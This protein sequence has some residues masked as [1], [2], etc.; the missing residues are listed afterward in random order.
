MAQTIIVTGG[1]RGIGKAILMHFASKGF[2][3]GFCSLQ[4]AHVESLQK[5]LEVLFPQQTIFGRAVDMRKRE[6]V[7]AFGKEVINK[8][9]EI[10]ILVNN[11]GTFLPGMVLEEPEGQLE[12]LI[13]T[14]LYS[15]YYMSRAIAPILIRSGKGHIFNI[16][17][18]AG[19]KAY[20]NGGSYSISKFAM[21]GLSKALREELKD[22]KV[23]VT[24]V[25]PGAVLTDSWSGVD[26][27]EDRFIAAA[28]V[29]KN[30]FDVHAL[31]DRTVI[32]DIVL[33]PQ[34]GDI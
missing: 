29:A 19:L 13:E 14:N 23:R 26:L 18:V 11:A 20:P 17:S 27:P 5:E 28:D 25:Y 7:V 34:L 9:K 15:A 8:F 12:K 24:T 2:H 1:S 6:E 31:S 10:D 33:R 3:V 22:K 4:P 32:E 21:Q 16:C 30:I